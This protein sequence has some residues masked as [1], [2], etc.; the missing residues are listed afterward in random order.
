MRESCWV[1]GKEPG[2]VNAAAGRKQARAAGS[3]GF[4]FLGHGGIVDRHSRAMAT[5]HADA[6]HT[7]LVFSDGGVGVLAYWEALCGRLGRSFSKS[8]AEMT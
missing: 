1:V 5:S 2:K 3:H 4:Q 6:I 8:A 7:V